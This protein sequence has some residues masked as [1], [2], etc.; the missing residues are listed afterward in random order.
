MALDGLCFLCLASLTLAALLTSQDKAYSLELSCSAGPVHVVLE[1]AQELMLDCNL[2]A[3]EQPVHISWEKDGVPVV[4][5]GILQVLPNGSLSVLQVVH[6]GRVQERRSSAEGSYSCTVSSSF[7]A[8]ASR[9]AVIRDTTLSRFLQHPESQVVQQSGLARFQC[10]IDGLPTPI[11]TWEKDQSLLPDQARFTPLPNG[12]L[13]IVNVQGED[14]GAYRCVA[15]NAART[16]YSQDAVLT[17]TEGPPSGQGDVVIIAAPRNT[18]VVAGKTAVMECMAQADPTPFVS[19]IRQDGKPIATDA[20]VLSTNLLIADTQSYHAGVYVCRANKPKTRQFVNAAAALRVLS[21]PVITQLPETISRTRASTGR[22]VC[23]ASGEPAPA[24]TWMKNG[25]LIHSNGRVKIQSSGSLVINQIAVEDSGYYQCIAE[26]NLGTACATARLSVIVREGLPS[27]PHSV[28][29]ATLS[30]TAVLVTWERPEHNSEQI[31]GFSLHYQRAAGGTDNVENQF[32]VNNDTTEFQV[33]DLEPNTNYT[34]YVVAYSPLGASRTS[35]L[36]TVHTS[37]DVPSAPPQLSLLSTTPTDIR[38]MWFPLSA[39]LSQGKV[40][41]YRIDYCTVEEVDQIY[42][43]EVAGNE[44]QVPLHSLHPNKT[45]KVRIAAGT[46]AGFGDPSEW[47]QHRTPDRDNQTMVLFAPLELK[48]RAKV[49]SLHVMWQPPSSHAQISGYKLCYRE[50]ELENLANEDPPDSPRRET[51]ARSPIRLKKKVKQYEI[52]GLAPDRL[53][54]VKVMA[55]SKHEDGYAA[56]W[57]GRTERAPLTMGEPPVQKVPPLPP[58]SVQAVSNSS[59]SIW[60][61][62]EKPSFRTVKIVNYTVRCN[63]WAVKNASLVSYYISSEEQILLTGLKPYTKYELAVQSNAVGV[64]GPFSK[65]VEQ[66]TLPDRPSSPPSGLQLSPLGPHSVLVRWQPPLEPNGLI[67]EYVV[68]YSSNSTQPDSMWSSLSREGNI[69][70]AEVKGLE[71]GTRYFFKMGAKTVMG[72]GPY[73]QVKEA[74][75][76]PEKHSEPDI[77]DIHSVTGIIVGVCLGLLCIL[78]C[79]WVSFRTSKQREIPQGPDLHSSTSPHSLYRKGR[80]A[81]ITQLECHDCHELETLMSPWPEDTSLPLTGITEL[82]EEHS[83][84]GTS[85]AEDS[86]HIELK[87]EVKNKATPLVSTHQMEALVIV[88]SELSESDRNGAG[89]VQYTQ[90]DDG[91]AM[92]EE[93]SDVLLTNQNIADSNEAG[94]ERGSPVLLNHNGKKAG[95][96]ELGDSHGLPNGFHIAEDHNQSLENGDSLQHDNRN[97]QPAKCQPFPTGPQEHPQQFASSGIINSTSTTDNYLCP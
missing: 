29:A 77:L 74:H 51:W 73:S 35:N 18:T 3:V 30:S 95:K 48:V 91:E 93:D 36:V 69:F 56:V 88:H 57:K 76:L 17:V 65:V 7:G 2:P 67:V 39:E 85:L 27:N 19:W 6:E 26:N 21:P 71:S 20:V 58:S 59:T 90:G 9:T 47:T 32:A 16:R 75:A 31:I 15:A 25:Q 4:S 80:P 13:Q 53:Y 61:R 41:K 87:S 28:S 34:F 86:L 68:L 1:P 12:V 11:I 5:N 46:S 81:P 82:T 70:S 54:E 55:F 50:A 24:I 8:I 72:A 49:D 22:F 96:P 60:L 84:M 14:A 37:E 23:K 78:L 94:R 43:I 10:R 97:C 66:S 40:T 33:K 38:V 64:D 42:S 62:W 44:T 89:P 45:Y 92:E 63:P 83:L 79:M 52:T